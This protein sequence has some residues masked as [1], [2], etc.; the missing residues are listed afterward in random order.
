MKRPSQDLAGGPK[1]RDVR[2]DVAGQSISR[3]AGDVASY[4][5]A[6]RDSMSSAADHAALIE[7]FAD[8]LVGDEGFEAGRLPAADR[9]FRERLRR[10]LWRHY[11]VSNLRNVGKKAH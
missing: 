2:P 6:L 11:V 5:H 7:D 3:D 1:I 8:F 10:R 4:C 9:V